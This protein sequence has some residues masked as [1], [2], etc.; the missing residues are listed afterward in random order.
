MANQPKQLLLIDAALSPIV[1]TNMKA[2]MNAQTLG[3]EFDLS[4]ISAC[5]YALYQINDA[6]FRFHSIGIVADGEN[7]SSWRTSIMDNSFAEALAKILQPE[8]R[9]STGADGVVCFI[10]HQPCVDLFACNMRRNDL[11]VYTLSS[12]LGRGISVYFSTNRTGNVINTLQDWVMEQ[13]T[14][15]GKRVIE[16]GDN[17][18]NVKTLYLT[19][20]VEQFAF[21]FARKE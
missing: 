4:N 13:C 14:Q 11:G 8:Q 9:E 21:R 12:N 18:R 1:R 17:E 10:E 19:D 15:G 16:K 5:L 2:S 20:R 7:L 3:I 6:T